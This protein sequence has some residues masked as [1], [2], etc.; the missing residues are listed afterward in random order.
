[1]AKSPGPNQTGNVPPRK[2]SAP[3]RKSAGSSRPPTKR[4][5]RRRNRSQGRFYGLVIGLV[6]GGGSS[7][8]TKQVAIN[9]TANGTK[10]YGGIGPEGVPLELGQQLASPN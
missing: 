9:F 2:S 3:P 8:I 4:A 5:P 1:M 6:T 7:S 10:V